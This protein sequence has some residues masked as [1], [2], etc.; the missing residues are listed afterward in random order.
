MKL[1]NFLRLPY[2]S[3]SDQCRTECIWCGAQNLE[4][5]REG[6][7]QFQCW[8]CKKT[9]NCY[10]LIQ[11]WYETLPELKPSEAKALCVL[12]PGIQPVTL[13]KLGIRC[14]LFNGK[15]E[16][17]WP[18]FNSDGHIV[19][20]YRYNAEEG[21]PL[22]TPKPCSLTVL[23]LESFK[24]TGT[25]YLL[26]GHW[27]YAAFLSSV[28][29]EGICVLG[30]C[31]SSYPGKHLHWLESRN[32]VFLTDND[33]AGREGVHSLATR[34]KKAGV[35]PLKL[36]YLDWNLVTLPKHSEVPEGFDIRDLIV[37]YS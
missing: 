28:P 16:W 33:N 20:L 37:E 13:R 2:T 36:S 14:R 31:G 25:I 22:S 6:N 9:G 15:P 35:L 17:I 26:E 19:C 18:V 32:V 29:T 24:K 10:T 8:S 11:G 1:L 30:V 21:R 3:T 12:K 7:H 5:M 23:G 4:I 34:M 27:D